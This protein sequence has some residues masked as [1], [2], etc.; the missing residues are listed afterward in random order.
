[1]TKKGMDHY[2]EAGKLARIAKYICNT[3]DALGSK[4]VAG[5]VCKG[6]CQFLIPT[7]L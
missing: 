1:M 4:S 7:E 2:N 6:F 3:S 5:K